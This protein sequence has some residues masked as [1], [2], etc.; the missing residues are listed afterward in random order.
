MT[1]SPL[2]QLLLEKIPEAPLT[3]ATTDLLVVADQAESDFLSSPRKREALQR[4]VQRALERRLERTDLGLHRDESKPYNW[5]WLPGRK[6]QFKIRMDTATA[7][8]FGMLRRHLDSLIPEPQRGELQPLFDK[9]LEV[10]QRNVDARIKRWETRAT[11]APAVFSLRPPEVKS[12]VL[13][14]TRLALLERNQLIIDYRKPFSE[15]PRRHQVHPQGLVLCDGVFYLF[16]NVGDRADPT[17]FVL[18]RI[19]NAQITSET[20]RDIPGFDV[21]QYVGDQRG[22][23]F[24]SGKTTTLR[25]RTSHFLAHILSERPLSDRQKIRALDEDW[26]QITATVPESEQLEWWIGSWGEQCEVLAPKRLRDRM[27]KRAQRVHQFYVGT[28]AQKSTSCS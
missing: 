3:I 7:L 19:E 20:S 5:Q 12:E 22:L 11:I 13:D 26:C 21:N 23:Q 10:V 2:E 6:R 4:H 16:A 14:Q 17:T 18:H 24:L 8:A 28:S 25:L 1:F 15:E 9:A 27:A